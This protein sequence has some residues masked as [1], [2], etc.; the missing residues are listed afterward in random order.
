MRLI[1][2]ASEFTQ[3]STRVVPG[4]I[5]LNA[6]LNEFERDGQH[7]VDHRGRDQH[8]DMPKLGL[9]LRSCD[10]HQLPYADYRNKRRVLEHGDELVACWRDNNA[11]RLW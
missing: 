4:V 8:F 6:G 11:H 9:A 2:S 1:E 10:I 7:P 5:A 3:G